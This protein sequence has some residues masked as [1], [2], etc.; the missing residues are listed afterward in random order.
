MVT[1]GLSILPN[2]IGTDLSRGHPLLFHFIAGLWATLFGATNTSLHTFSLLLATILLILVYFVGSKL[3][4]TQ[5]GMAALLL[6]GLNEMFLAQSTIF[7]PEI[8][9]A[10]SLLLAAWAYINRNI[11]GYIAAATCSL[12]IKESAVVFI[13]ALICWHVISVL[14]ANPHGKPQARWIWITIILSPLIPAFLFLLYQR[15]TYGW[16]F[17]PIHLGLISLD[18]RD[19]HYLFKF[20]YRDLFEQQGMEWA[21]LAFGLLAPLAWKGWQKRYTGLIV[22][23]IYVATIK[24]LDGKWPLPPFLTLLVTFACL[25]A[26]LILQFIPLRKQEGFR[27][28]FPAISLIFVIGFLLFSAMNFFTD[29]YLICLLPFVSLSLSAVLYSSLHPWHK[30]IFPVVILIISTNLCWNIGRDRRV[31]DTRL[32]Y[33]DDIHVHQL[34]ITECEKLKMQDSIFY[35]SFMDIAYMTDFNAGYLK[36]KHAFQHVTNILSSKTQFAIVDQGSPSELKPHLISL[37]FTEEK[38]YRS[39]PAW[40]AIFER[41]GNPPTS[42]EE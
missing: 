39:G 15:L 29:R 22:V 13:I 26:T 12:F 14:L 11:A 30:A 42:N 6:I 19:I 9:L 18:V 40:C 36:E 25:G 3:G 28:E 23:I 20:G 1:N 34:L 10:I 7:L 17:Y 16:F 8:A 24:V 33:V 35:G 32:S 5:I 38:I 27:G 31:G 21:T 4:S 37:G 41:T 2:T